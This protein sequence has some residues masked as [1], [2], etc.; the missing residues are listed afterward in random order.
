MRSFRGAVS[1]WIGRHFAAV[2][3]RG[4]R[5][6]LQIAFVIDNKSTKNRADAVYWCQPFNSILKTFIAIAGKVLEE[7]CC[8]SFGSSLL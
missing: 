8:Q 1:E 6:A 7:D 2:C 5:F 3:G 4:H